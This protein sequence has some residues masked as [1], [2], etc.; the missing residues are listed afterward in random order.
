VTRNSGAIPEVTGRSKMP[1]SLEDL[2]KAVTSLQDHFQ[3][4][5]KVS[6]RLMKQ[7]G[8][9]KASNN[10]FLGESAWKSDDAAW[11]KKHPDRAHRLRPIFDGELETMSPEV[12][13]LEIPD[14]HRLEIIVRQ[15]EVGKRIRT[16]FCRNIETPIPNVEEIIHAIFDSVS[17]PAK[18][19][20]ISV[21]EI[22]DLA[23]KYSAPNPSKAN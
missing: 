15:V 10:V 20:V 5:D 16:I 12:M 8:L 13:A 19:G 17:Q 2:D 7:A 14:K 23:T 1:L 11:F 22:A 6:G 4:V 3:E 18:H 9:K 21:K